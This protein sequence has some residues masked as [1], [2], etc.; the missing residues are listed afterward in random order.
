MV[1]I[2]G[3]ENTVAD[4]CADLGEFALVDFQL[5]PHNAGDFNSLLVSLTSPVQILALPAEPG[6]F[7]EDLSGAPVHCGS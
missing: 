3:L 5:K 4:L 1:S 7:C 2:H 6:D